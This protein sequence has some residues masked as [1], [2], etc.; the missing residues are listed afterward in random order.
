MPYFSLELN[1]QAGAWPDTVSDLTDKAIMTAI[2]HLA[3]TFDAPTELSILLTDDDTIAELNQ[4]WRQ[5]QGSTNVLSFPQIA[6]FSTPV[7]LLGDIILASQTLHREADAQAI[8]LTD[9]YTHLVI[10]GFLHILGYDHINDDEARVM[11][12]LETAILAR[13]NIT[14]PYAGDD[15]SGQ[16]N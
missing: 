1:Q 13:L 16:G 8:N 10:H 2:E 4:Q 11:E 9:H 7:G 14:D 3:L 5:T 12:R 6:A 15:V